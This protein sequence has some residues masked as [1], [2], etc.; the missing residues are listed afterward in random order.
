MNHHTYEVAV[1]GAGPGGYVAAIKAAQAGKRTCIIESGVCGGVC[2]NEGCIPTKT[3]LRSAALLGEI[4]EA[5]KYGIVGLDPSTASISMPALQSRKLEVIRQLSGGVE[6]LLKANGATLIKGRA[7]FTDPHT[8]DISGRSVSADAFI[9]AAGSEAF[10]P[11]FIKLEGENTL[12]TS[13]EALD[14]AHVPASMAVIGGGVIGVEFA[15]LLHMLGCKVTVLELLEEILPMVDSD[16]SRAA[17]RRMERDGIVFHLGAKVKTVRDNTVLYEKDGQERFVHT[18]AV[19][20]AVGRVPCAVGLNAEG[21]GIAF[22]GKAIKTDAHLRTNIPHIYAVGDVNGKSMLAHTASHEAVVAVGNICGQPEKMRYDRI[23]ACI[24]LDPEI[25]GIGMT[26][27]KG[28]ERGK[29]IAVGIFPLAANGKSL[30]EGDT[31][32]LIKVIVDAELGEVLGVHMYGKRVTDMI[33]EI[34]TAMTLEATPEEIIRTVHPHPTVS[35]A[36]PEAFMKAMG[37]AVHIL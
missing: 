21:I 7:M 8:V 33:A 34:A 24:Y 28:R 18:E 36:V 10:M 35:E 25:A 13:R 22:D 16:V 26:E 9:I 17:R 12:L 19:L 1:I 20:M 29:N 14:L 4:R 2:L 31:D 6:G 23:P 11:P 3:L 32:G 37:K 30:V 5:A 15:Y 27:D